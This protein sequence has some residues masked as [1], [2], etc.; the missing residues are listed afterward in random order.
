VISAINIGGGPDLAV[1]FDSTMSDTEDPD[2]EGPPWNSGNLSPDTELGRLLIIQENDI[3]ENNDGVMDNPDDEGSRPAGSIFFDFMG[4]LRVI[5]FDII[6]VDN[7]DEFGDDAGYVGLFSDNTELFRLKISDLVD[8]LSDV[9]DPSIVL[10]DNSAN[11]V[12]FI[13]LREL[14]NVNKLEFNLGGSG[15]IDNIK[16]N[17][18]VPIPGIPDSISD[19]KLMVVSSTQV[20]LSWSVPNDGGS[21]IIG[22]QIV[23][24]LN[25]GGFL[26]LIAILG[27]SV[28]SYSDTT[29]SSGDMV[30]YALRAVNANGNAFPSNFPAPVTTP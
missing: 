5:S 1:A 7:S 29:L 3:D 27:D 23:R 30:N 17:R 19:L 20:D 18:C 26:P 15:A 9:Y 25:G 21:P 22:Y 2:L 14:G 8:S 16:W 4:P 28:T 12:A 6:D 13:D 11:R 10:G 24:N